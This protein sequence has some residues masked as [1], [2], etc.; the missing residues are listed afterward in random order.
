M[1]YCGSVPMLMYWIE[2]NYNT[3]PYYGYGVSLNM[4]REGSVVYTPSLNVKD[5]IIAVY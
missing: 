1:P 5:L 2:F 3:I 4:D